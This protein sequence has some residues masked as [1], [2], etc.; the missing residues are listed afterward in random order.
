LAA[1][2]SVPVNIAISSTYVLTSVLPA[3]EQACIAG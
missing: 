2:I 1:C 3:V